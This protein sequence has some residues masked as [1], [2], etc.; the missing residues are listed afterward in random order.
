[1]KYI[2][3][4]LGNFGSSVASR[5][6]DMG[7]D[8][9]G[10]DISQLRCDE[11]RDSVSGVVCMDTSIDEALSSL[12]L[13]EAEIIIVAIGKDFASSIK[14][15]AQL[16][17]LGVR[18]IIARGLNSVHIGVL[19]TLGVERVIFPEKDGAEL[20]SQSL[21]YGDFLSSYRVDAT[22]YIIQFAAP[23]QLIGLSIGDSQMW[24]D[25]EL[26]VITIKQ[27]QSKRN[28]LGLSH[29]ERAVVGKVSP[30]TIIETGDILVVYGTIKSYDSFI[31]S[32]K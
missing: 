23:K 24:Q 22:H 16:R 27:A 17:K 26:Q 32:I 19:Q 25:Y 7:H 4:G 13:L 20:L 18:R 6:T 5:L 10:A 14:T 21:N 28:I 8:V 2:V 12:P 1:M 9:I 29:S 31:R 11:L 3:L 15:V 30:K